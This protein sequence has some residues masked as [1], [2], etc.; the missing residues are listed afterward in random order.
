[1]DFSS[2]FSFGSILAHQTSSGMFS[3]WFR[4][5]WQPW[6]PWGRVNSGEKEFSGQ[7]ATVIT[8]Y[9]QKHHSVQGERGGQNLDF[10]TTLFMDGT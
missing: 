3:E 10:V 5:I 6:G 7:T 1:M 8:A 2:L 4:F 9:E